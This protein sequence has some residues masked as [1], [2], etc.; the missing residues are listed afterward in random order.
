MKKLIQRGQGPE[1]EQYLDNEGVWETLQ[2]VDK[3]QDGVTILAQ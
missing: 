2:D 1:L 3:Y